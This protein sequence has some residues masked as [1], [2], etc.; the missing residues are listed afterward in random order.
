MADRNADFAAAMVPVARA[1]WGEPNKALSKAGELRYGNGGS[2]SVDVKKG[3]WFDHENQVG[4]GVIDLVKREKALTGREVID[5]IEQAASIKLDDGRRPSDSP[6]RSRRENGSESPPWDDGAPPHG[7]PV[8]AAAA[9]ARSSTKRRIVKTYDYTDGE[10]GLLYQ[11]VRF[12]PKGFAQRR[13]NP[14]KRGDWIWNLEGL[15]HG[16]YRLPELREAL[17]AEETVFIA[18]GEKDVDSL[19]AQGIA[20]TTNSGG[21]KHWSAVHAEMFRGRDVVVPIDNDKAG[22]ERG[23]AI[24]RSLH[25]VARRIRILDVAAQVP[26]LAE[27]GD[28]SDWIADGATAETIFDAVGR[29]AA[30]SPPRET[31]YGRTSWRDLDKPSAE[32]EFL[33]DDWLTTGDK[34]ILAGASRSG[35]SFLAIDM[36][37][38]IALGRPWF[39]NDVKQGLVVYQAGEGGRGLKRRLRAFRQHFRIE[40]D[41]DVPF[42]LLTAKVD[43]Y[44]P[45]D[46]GGD[47]SKFIETVKNIAAETPDMPL[48]AVFID[49]LSVAQGGADEISGK[50]MGAVLANVDRIS[51]E[52][53]AHVCLVHHMNADGK[54]LRGHTSLLANVDEVLLV[55]RNETTNVRTVT[56]DKMKD[57]EDGK[58]LQFE[59]LAVDV[60]QREDGKRLTSCVCLPV[61]EKEAIR[62]EEQQKGYVLNPGEI[63]LMKA[64]FA[65]E[66]RYGKPVPADM[67]IASNVR[68]V[69]EWTHVLAAYAEANPIDEDLSAMTEDEAAKAKAKHKDLHKKRVKRCREYLQSVGVLGIGGSTSSVA[70]FTGKPLRAF[71]HTQPK[72][73]EPELPSALDNLS[74]EDRAA[75]T[76]IPF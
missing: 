52:T 64:F 57:G 61:G 62:K 41:A 54:K 72:P 7:E 71:P 22:R 69:V 19:W 16:L 58:K 35:K 20:A 40:K 73:A 5:F 42:E 9:P 32:L 14:D 4:G 63:M 24:A 26:G 76:S 56:L 2:R 53:G 1:I 46:A 29:L 27:K 74:P 10:G 48:R 49:T 12:E 13:P 31:R 23:E 44:A 33:V 60:G 66:K 28:I 21:A 75:M 36:G 67:A 38:S 45:D 6:P 55:T 37:L 47:T 3:T 15:G 68:T 51:R 11:V 65:A 30:W 17:A 43:L 8:D 59:L 70:W 34:S 25:G 18:E 50:D 39:G